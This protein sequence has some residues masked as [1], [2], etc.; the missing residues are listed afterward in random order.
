VTLKAHEVYQTLGASVGPWFKN[1]GFRRT[2]GRILGWY[3]PMDGEYL[4]VS[5]WCWPRGS[6]KLAGSKFV[7]EIELAAKPKVFSRPKPKS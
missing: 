3:R 7:V 4:I 2:K 1:Q 6:D 5:F